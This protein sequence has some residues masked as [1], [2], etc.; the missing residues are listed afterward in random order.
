[1]LNIRMRVICFCIVSCNLKIF[2]IGRVKMM[3]FLMMLKM[4]LEIVMVVMFKYFVVID[5]FYIV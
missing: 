2:L 1:M 4:V 3:M 5:L